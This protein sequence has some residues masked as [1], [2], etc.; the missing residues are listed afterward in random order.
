MIENCPECNKAYNNNNSS[1]RGCFDDRR[2]AAG[3]HR[4]FSNQRVSVHQ[5]LG[6][7]ASIYD[8]LGGK[9]NVHDQLGGRVNEKSNNQLEEIVDSLVHD[10]DI[11]CRAPERRCTLQLDEESS[12]SC[13]KPNRQWCLD[14]LTKSQKRRV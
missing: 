13:K 10:E 4:E 6:G 8:R 14:G 7:K 1:K 5:R 12:Q 9:T 2:P 3:D 11:M